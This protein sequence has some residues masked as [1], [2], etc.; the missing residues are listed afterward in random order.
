MTEPM[1][2]IVD[3]EPEVLDLL[4]RTLQ[5]HHLKCACAAGVERGK[6]AVESEDPDV[7]VCDVALRDGSGLE[8]LKYIRAA[9]PSVP[10]IIITGFPSIQVAEEALRL[11]AFDLLE[12]PFDLHALIEVVNEALATREQQLAGI[13]EMLNVVDRPAAFVD[14]RHRVMAGNAKWEQ[15]VGEAGR[16]VRRNIDEYVAASSPLLVSDLLAGSGAADSAE[17][18]LN[19]TS[20]DG[21]VPVELVAVPFRERREQPGGFL[22]TAEPVFSGPEGEAGNSSAHLDPLTGCLSLRGFLEALDRMRLAA[23]RRS[24][25]VAILLVDIDDFRYVNQSQGY[26]LGDQILQDLA[27]EIRR[28]VRPEDLVGRYGG[29]EFTVAL[30][31]ATADDAHAAANRLIAALAGQTYDVG[32]LSLPVSLTIGVTECPAGYTTDN[33]ALLEQAQAAARWGRQ[34]HRGP[35]VRYEKEMASGGDRLTVNQEEIERLSQEFALANERLKASYVES[36]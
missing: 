26:E 21:P 15:L 14:R 23:L 19:L 35:V 18:R 10:V 33:R 8:L 11:G 4:A 29:D 1:L 5:E 2:L 36:V 22:I 13:R 31:E 20:P 27:S 17:A 32:G 6:L 24:L 25:P 9:K 28:M 34:N 12:K 7:V 16:N 3:D 30:S